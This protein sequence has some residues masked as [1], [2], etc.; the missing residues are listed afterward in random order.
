V[1]SGYVVKGGT[2]RGYWNT[3]KRVAVQN[4]N[5][6]GTKVGQNRYKTGTEVGQKWTFAGRGGNKS[7]GGQPRI[8]RD[9]PLKRAET[10]PR[11]I[12]PSNRLRSVANFQAVNALSCVSKRPKT[13][14]RRPVCRQRPVLAAKNRN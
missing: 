14:Y 8:M 10:I 3:A 9:R 2:V 7:L 4:R 6:S 13:R 11:R 12:R 1:K 5:R